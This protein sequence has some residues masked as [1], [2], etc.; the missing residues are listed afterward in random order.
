MPPKMVKFKQALTKRL[1]SSGKGVSSSFT[2]D[3]PSLFPALPKYANLQRID[4][5]SQM[6]S[7]LLSGTGQSVVF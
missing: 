7:A 2:V 6:G 1:S 3:A 4:G 5:R